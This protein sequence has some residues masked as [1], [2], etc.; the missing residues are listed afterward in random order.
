ML[1]QSLN[2]SEDGVKRKSMN[3]NQVN[4]PPLSPKRQIKRLDFTIKFVLYLWIASFVI[5]FLSKAPIISFSQTTTYV[6]T[7]EGTGTA[8]VETKSISANTHDI[9]LNNEEFDFDD[10]FV[11]QCAWWG[12]EIKQ[13]KDIL[14]MQEYQKYVYAYQERSGTG[15]RLS[16]VMGALFFALSRKEKLKVQWTLIDE[17]FSP[18][19]LFPSDYFE[20]QGSRPNHYNAYKCQAKT[21]YSCSYMR[22]QDDHCPIFNR[23]CM[24]RKSCGRLLNVVNEEEIQMHHVIGCPLRALLQVKNDFYHH[25]VAWFINGELSE[26]NL[27]ELIDIMKDFNVVAVH[28]RL[29]DKY[30][31]RN[32]M[33]SLPDTSEEFSLINATN[34]CT[35]RVFNT[36]KNNKETKFLIASDDIR[37][38][39]YY[40]KYHP[41]EVIILRSKPHHIVDIRRESDAVKIKDEKDLFA[42]WLVI[43]KADELITNRAHRFGISAFSRTAWLYSLRS[44]YYEVKGDELCSRKE[45]EYRGNSETIAPPCHGNQKHRNITQLHIA[46]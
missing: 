3:F 28:L 42:E 29:G 5:I 37:V 23:A 45:F 27:F 7:L 46:T 31:V 4:A 22:H 44:I 35:R 19:C 36:F 18:S 33:N 32:K 20:L 13:W 2:K 24:T 25:E 16:G 9:C 14:D 40:R 34:R 6:A 10:R 1:V 30:L 21:Y 11:S 43:S 8:R 12:N 17:I 26:G 41:S 38:K 15:D 39:N